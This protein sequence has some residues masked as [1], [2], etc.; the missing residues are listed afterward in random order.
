MIKLRVARSA[1]AGWLLSGWL[2]GMWATCFGCGTLGD[3]M[4]PQDLWPRTPLRG[5]VL[6]DESSPFVLLQSGFDLDNPTTEPGPM[7]SPLR[8]FG[9]ISP[10]N[11]P[12]QAQI[13]V[14]AVTS[15]A[16]ESAPQEL[17]SPTLPWE[18]KGIANPMWLSGLPDQD[19]V[20]LYTTSDGAVGLFR[21]MQDGTLSRLQR[22]LIPAASLRNGKLGRLSPVISDGALRLYFTI[23][24]TAVHYAQ[25]DARAVSAFVSD[26]SRSVS[27]S[28]SPALLSASDVLISVTRSQTAVAERLTG[29]FVRRVLTPA[30]RARYDLY[31]RAEAMG[32]VALVAAS[33]YQGDVRE[34]FL[35]V[36]DPLLAA[37]AGGVPSGPYVTEWNG[38]TLLL[39]GL[40]TVQTG[41]A[42]AQLPADLPKKP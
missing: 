11:Q 4:P 8:L 40:R 14:S 5:F 3:G 29:L 2:L 26:D 36:S 21:R 32:K 42:V 22:P 33:S 6:R 31:A 27:F 17:L 9:Q 1:L 16:E 13:F 20:M 38:R 19:P 10:R 24:D 7:G 18:G 39:L 23:D 37:T 25:A 41:I 30:G 28:V 12:E 35:A 34:P 15:L